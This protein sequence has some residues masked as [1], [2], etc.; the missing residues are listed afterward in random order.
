M[1]LEQ[2]AEQLQRQQAQT[3]AGIVQ[4]LGDTFDKQVT[5]LNSHSHI[6]STP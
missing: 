2:Q 6:L 5:S 3:A 1:E 4:E